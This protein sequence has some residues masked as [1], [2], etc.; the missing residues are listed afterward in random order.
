MALTAGITQAW[1]VT[2]VALQSVPVV[3]TMQL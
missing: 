3:G 1:A 2:A